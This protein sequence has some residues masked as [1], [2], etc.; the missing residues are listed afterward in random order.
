MTIGDRVRAVCRGPY[1]GRTGTYAG[2]HLGELG[3]D[4]RKTIPEGD[5]PRATAWFRPGELVKV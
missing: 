3:A 1:N 4:F 5:K 2:Q